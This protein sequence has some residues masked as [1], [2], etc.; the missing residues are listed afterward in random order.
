MSLFDSAASG[1]GSARAFSQRLYRFYGGL[2]L[3]FLVFIALLMLAEWLR[4]PR[5]WLG[6]ISLLVPVLVY[7]GIGI[8][9]R[10]ADA[11]EYY[12]AGRRVPAFFN[13]MAT[14]ADWMSAASFVGLVGTV[15]IAGYGGLA[16]IMGWTGGFCLVALLIAPYL[17]RFGQYTIPDFLGAR[18]EG[19]LPR[20]IGAAAA[21][22]PV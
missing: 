3:A 19:S 18:Y 7:A 8:L 12:V 9:S 17:N 22:R 14:A 21:R 10:T 4:L 13:G 5:I 20:L 16:Y 15:Y 6:M 1:G 11:D 2:T